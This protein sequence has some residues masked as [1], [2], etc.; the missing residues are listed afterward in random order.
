[1]KKFNFKNIARYAAVLFQIIQVFLLP[2]QYSLFII[3]ILK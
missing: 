2:M 1:M 3:F